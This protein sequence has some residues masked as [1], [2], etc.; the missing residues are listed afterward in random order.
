MGLWTHDLRSPWSCARLLKPPT[1]KSLHNVL[2]YLSISQVH[3][4]YNLMLFWSCFLCHH[5]FELRLWIFRVEEVLDWISDSH[6]SAIFCLKLDLSRLT[7]QVKHDLPISLTPPHFYFMTFNV[8]G[9]IKTS[10]MHYI[11]LY[12]MFIDSEPQIFSTA[13]KTTCDLAF[14]R[15]CWMMEAIGNSAPSTLT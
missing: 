13:F 15:T 7:V 12:V 14:F 3:W 6:S 10:Q 4:P 11:I 9:F 1:L 8:V 2:S 5:F